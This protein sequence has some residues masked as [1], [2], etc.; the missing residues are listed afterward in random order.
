MRRFIAL[1]L[2]ALAPVVATGCG[3]D[4]PND[5][6]ASIAGTYT[7]LSV[8]GV[9]LPITVLEGNP[10][11]EV[12]RDDLTLASGGAVTRTV[13][14]R[15]T[16]DGVPSTQSEVARG[17]FTVSG[18]TVSIRMADDPTIVTGAVSDRTITIVADGST[19]IYQRP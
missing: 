3:S 7:L 15:F 8:D 4:N 9:A 18:S 19:L 5:P 14:F 12:V 6:T 10:K 17:T 1:V 16:Q 2:L 11:I 13:A